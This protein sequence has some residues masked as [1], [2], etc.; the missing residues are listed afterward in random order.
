MKLTKTESAALAE[1][2][3]QL[4]LDR[5]GIDRSFKELVHILTTVT[6]GINAEIDAHNDRILQ[7]QAFVDVVSARLRDIYDEKSERWQE[8]EAGAAALE[9]VEAWEHADLDA[10]DM[11]VVLAPDAPNESYNESLNLPEEPDI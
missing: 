6:E 11:V 5:E 8:S 7:A 10:L 2:A 1:H 9:M 4:R 3:L